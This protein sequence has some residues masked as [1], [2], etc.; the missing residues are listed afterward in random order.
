MGAAVGIK[1]RV[2]IVSGLGINLS[3]PGIGVAGRFGH[4]GMCRVEDGEM[5]DDE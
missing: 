4:G 3:V 5:E 2:G 1:V